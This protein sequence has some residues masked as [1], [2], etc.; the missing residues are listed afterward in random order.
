MRSISGV[1]GSR[2]SC[3]PLVGQIA[4]P[5]AHFLSRG[6][7]GAGTEQQHNAKHTCGQAYKLFFQGEKKAVSRIVSQKQQENIA[8][9]SLRMVR[10]A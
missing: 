10:T 7:C 9:F 8:F 3:Q 1:A 4:D 2:S 6:L 5:G